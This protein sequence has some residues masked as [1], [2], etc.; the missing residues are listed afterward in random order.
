[1][2][3]KI[4]F[5]L[6]IRDWEKLK[7]WNFAINHK[8]ISLEKSAKNIS[9][10]RF[11]FLNNYW[12]SELDGTT[13]W[14]ILLMDLRWGGLSSHPSHPVVERVKTEKQTRQLLAFEW[15]NLKLGLKRGQKCFLFPAVLG[16]GSRFPAFLGPIFPGPDVL[17]FV[18]FSRMFQAYWN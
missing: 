13:N 8:F 12:I 4:L 10:S 7:N 9:N 1:M 16:L 2:A 11:N 6:T 14:Q 15:T 18:P 3:Q 17:T 5:L